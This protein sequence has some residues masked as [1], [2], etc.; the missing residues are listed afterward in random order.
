MSQD[1]AVWLLLTHTLKPGLHIW[2]TCK[3]TKV[4]YKLCTASAKSSQYV[5]RL[6]TYKPTSCV[7]YKHKGETD[8]QMGQ[9]NL[10]GIKMYII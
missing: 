3:P 8:V 5:T 10:N 6:L 7:S 4:N 1:A 9:N 2:P